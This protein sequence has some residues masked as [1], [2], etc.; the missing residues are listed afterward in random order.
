L[1]AE[2]NLELLNGNWALVSA[3]LMVI[4]AMYLLH[5]GI[6]RWPVRRKQ[7]T[8]GM[9]LATA[10]FITGLG[11]L[12]R[13][14]ETWRWRVM[15]GDPDDLDQMLI[16]IGGLLAAIGFLCMIREISTRLFGQ[17]PWLITLAAMALFTVIS[18]VWRL[19]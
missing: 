1:S 6:A 18:L 19:A 7:F 2:L 16:S 11:G 17:L 5:E 4:C 14:A 12:I 3:S 15:G 13:S 10:M 8:V 9:R